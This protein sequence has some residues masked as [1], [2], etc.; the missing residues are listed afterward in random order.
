MKIDKNNNGWQFKRCGVVDGISGFFLVRHAVFVLYHGDVD[1]LPAYVARGHMDSNG[2]IRH[3]N[4]TWEEA[5][6]SMKLP[7][8][9]DDSTEEDNA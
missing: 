5:I 6:S 3:N 8:V 7:S 9:F 4:A 1:A 2:S